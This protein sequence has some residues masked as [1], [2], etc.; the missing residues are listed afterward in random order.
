MAEQ[1]HV[2]VTKNADGTFAAAVTLGS[3]TRDFDITA[4]DERDAEVRALV[5]WR[6]A[7]AAAGVSD[8]MAA[9][10]GGLADV[11]TMLSDHAAMLKGVSADILTLKAKLSALAA[12]APVPP[13]SPPGAPAGATEPAKPPG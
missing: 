12:P 11:R 8:P 9:V 2:Q 13:P 10:I 3:V 5:A 6:A 1:P 7:D 4:Q